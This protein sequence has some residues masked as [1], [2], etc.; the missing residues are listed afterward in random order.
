MDQQ[1][2]LPGQHPPPRRPHVRQPPLPG[3]TIIGHDRIR[4]AIREGGEPRSAPLFTEVDWGPV[5]L[6]PPFLTFEDR[7]TVHV[8]DLVC[9][10][11]YAGT[12]THTD[13]ASVVWIPER[14]SPLE[15]AL[16]ADLGE[17]AELLDPE[18]LVGNLHRAYAEDAGTAPGAAVDLGAACADM[19]T[20]NDGRPLSCH[21]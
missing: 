13:N 17:Y 19:I 9:D 14:V 10:V 18:R 8:D 21:A 7:V 1:H 4:T 6:A 16:G 20:F 15:A 12:P 2:R 3:A 5:E 11:R